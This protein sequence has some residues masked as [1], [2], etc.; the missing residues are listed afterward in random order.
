MC[1]TARR[2]AAPILTLVVA[3]GAAAD[4]GCGKKGPPLAP[5][6]IVPVRIADVGAR[7]QSADVAV[8]FTLPQQNTDNTKPANLTSVEVYAITGEP[9]DPAGKPLDVREFIRYATLVATVEV[10]PPPEPVEEGPDPAGDETAPAKPDDPR[11]AQ[12]ELVTV[13]E[14]LSADAWTPFEH[15]N[16]AKFKRRL[17]ERLVAPLREYPRALGWPPPY[18]PLSRSY[19]ALSVNK[20]G[21][22]S[23]MSNRVAVPLTDPPPPTVG[24]ELTIN[25]T[26]VV[27]SWPVPA[28]AR[29]R[30]TPS[31]ATGELTPRVI[32]GGA[33][34]HTYNV[35]AWPGEGDPPT[36]LAP[37]NAT[38]IE[39]HEL[40]MAAPIFDVSRCYAVR[41]VETLGRATVEGPLS[42]PTCVTPRDTFAPQAPQR[43]SAVGSAGGVNMFWE[44][45]TEADLAG[46]LVLRAA[47]PGE[48]T[49][50]LDEQPTRDT[51]FHDTSATP[52]VRY[53]YAIVA[54]DTHGNRSAL[55]NR[56]EE[57][58]R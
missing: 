11:P 35:Y 21:Q 29:V 41:A 19:V 17:E 38:A 23:A 44:A 54:V 36:A 57:A 20:K 12:G 46:Y 7:R 49:E 40:T 5:L 25:E 56:V 6:V 52:G 10:E 53:V 34:P 4:T 15:R 37:I 9:S 26:S 22:R 45:N 55:S 13:H 32:L 18:V 2:A 27:A 3:S 28:T 39:G 47:A 16:A 33:S 31:P 48:P 24:P 42:P 51:T 58:A 1:R 50:A 14:L 8:S 43:L 30:L